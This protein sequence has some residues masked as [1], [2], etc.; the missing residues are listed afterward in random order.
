MLRIRKF[1]VVQTAKVAAILYFF[2]TAIMLVPFGIIFL[3]VDSVS[4][5]FG[6]TEGVF[7]SVIFLFA[8]IIYAVVGFV[9]VA[10]GC[11]IYN[12]VSKWV[13]GIEVEVEDQHLI[14][15]ESNTSSTNIAQISCPGCNRS[16]LEASSYC[17]HCGRK[18]TGV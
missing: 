11:P 18:I 15:V 3:A 8:P 4:D 17:P 7:G 9:F 1:G 16:V 12:L 5:D 6:A 10:I 13:G 14:P 2:I